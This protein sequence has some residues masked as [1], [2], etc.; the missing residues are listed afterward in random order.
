VEGDEVEVSMPGHGS[1]CAQNE[2]EWG[3]ES[4]HRTCK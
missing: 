4:I 1:I 3:V 2:R